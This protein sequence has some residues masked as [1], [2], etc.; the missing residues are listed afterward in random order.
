MRFCYLSLLTDIQPSQS[1]CF[2]GDH[3]PLAHFRR[4]LSREPV[5]IKEQN[6]I[7]GKNIK[8]ENKFSTTT[9]VKFFYINFIF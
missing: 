1:S 2:V 3:L 7:T 4:I 9:K 8:N 5:R 6:T